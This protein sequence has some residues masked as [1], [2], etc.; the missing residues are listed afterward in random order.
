MP[1]DLAAEIAES[2][3]DLEGVD[4]TDLGYTLEE[5]IPADAIRMLACHDTAS[6]RLWFELPHHQI[7]ITSNDRIFVDGI[8]EEITS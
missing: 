6:W 8:H 1:P 3:A 4:P 5:Y 2:V 7:T